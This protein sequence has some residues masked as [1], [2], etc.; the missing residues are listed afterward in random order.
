VNLL[1]DEGLLA[2][3]DGG[4]WSLG[5]GLET[6]AGTAPTGL[7][8]V[9][10]RRLRKL[11]ASARR[12]LTLG[13]VIGDDFETEVL[14]G[15]ADELPVVIEASLGVLVE[16]WFARQSPRSWFDSRSER[17]VVLWRE[18]ARRGTFDLASKALRRVAYESAPLARRKIMH[19]EVARA[20]EQRL[21]GDLRFASEVLAH[22]FLLA[23]DWAA[24][25]PHLR[26]SAEKALRLGAPDVAQEYLG[27]A[28]AL[29]ISPP[30]NHNL[31]TSIHRE[32]HRVET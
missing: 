3:V 9:I 8:E 25:L 15:A 32:Y 1:R 27:A 16:R 18:G 29:S 23:E 12:L 17:D 13:A 2:P 4:R 26:A 28:E 5:P 22:H 7:E 14:Q 6:W 20:I 31:E 30:R 11:P 21:G 24:A 10:G 19:G